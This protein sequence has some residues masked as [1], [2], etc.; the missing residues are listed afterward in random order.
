MSSEH[1]QSIMAKKGFNVHRRC[2]RRLGW[3]FFLGGMLF[4][5]MTR[6][7][8]KKSSL[9]DSPIERESFWIYI[10][11]ARQHLGMSHCMQTKPLAKCMRQCLASGTFG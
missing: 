6:H 1:V 3:L 11:E 8:M 5:M 2:K 4:S 7:F 10:T 9:I